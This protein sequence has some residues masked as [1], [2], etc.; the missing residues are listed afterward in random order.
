MAPPSHTVHSDASAANLRPPSADASH[1][2]PIAAALRGQPTAEASYSAQQLQQILDTL[3]KRMNETMGLQVGA[4]WASCSEPGLQPTLHASDNC[5][6]ACSRA[7]LIRTERT[8][9]QPGRSF[10]KLP[11]RLFY[12]AS[13]NG[14]LQLTL[15]TCCEHMQKKQMASLDAA[16]AADIM[17]LVL[18][19]EKKLVGFPISEA[20]ILSYFVRCPISAAPLQ[21]CDHLRCSA[22]LHLCAEHHAALSDGQQFTFSARLS[23]SLLLHAILSFSPSPTFGPC[24]AHA[25]HA[26]L[27]TYFSPCLSSRSLSPLPAPLGARCACLYRSFVTASACEDIRASAKRARVSASVR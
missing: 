21:A 13:V 2:V 11:A 5:C 27:P 16:T 15:L 25:L 9:G 22:P 1:L 23:S 24:G 17:Q 4:S 20:F 26:A 19:I 12:D 7:C 18:D 14:A 6:I 8:V 3:R 10:I